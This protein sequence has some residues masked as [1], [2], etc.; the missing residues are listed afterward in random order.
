MLNN[1]FNVYN[2]VCISN[3]IN[4]HIHVSAC[5]HKIINDSQFIFFIRSISFPLEILRIV[6]HLFLFTSF[7]LVTFQKGN[8]KT[9]IAL[10][11]FCSFSRSPSIILIS[12][13]HYYMT[14]CHLILIFFLYLIYR[15]RDE[16][17]INLIS[18]SCTMF[19]FSPLV[20]SLCFVRRKIH[21]IY[22]NRDVTG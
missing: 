11:S 6:L 16:S 2:K 20:A 14:R 8:T 12:Y 4:N 15:L 22:M 21:I 17:C 7:K 1:L 3:N 5:N 9:A 19:F 18:F 13:K 10:L